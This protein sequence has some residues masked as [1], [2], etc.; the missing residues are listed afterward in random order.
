MDVDTRFTIGR[1]GIRP[2]LG[3]QTAAMLTRPWAEIA[4]TLELDTEGKVMA[5]LASRDTWSSIDVLWPVDGEDERLPIEMSGLPVFDRERRFNGY[6]GFGVCREVD[7]LAAIQARRARAPD[8]GAANRAAGAGFHCAVDRPRHPRRQNPAT[9]LSTSEHVAFQELGHELSE[10]L[11]KAASK[12]KNADKKPDRRRCARRRSRA[13]RG[14]T[15]TR[16]ERAAED[17]AQAAIRSATRRKRAPS[18]SACRPASWSI[19]STI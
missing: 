15:A 14:A 8:T 17:R 12:I 4:E 2:L 3:P 11:K 13:G 9:G 19:A 16:G 6:R 5:A 10:R 1:R 7:R 18:L